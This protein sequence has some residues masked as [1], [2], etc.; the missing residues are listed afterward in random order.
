MSGTASCS[1]GPLREDS[2]TVFRLWAPAADRVEL[3][4]EGTGQ[5]DGRPMERDPAGWHRLRV[6]GALPGT[7]YRF[8]LP[9]GLLVPDPASRLQLLDAEGPSVVVDDRGYP[10]ANPD[11]TDMIARQLALLADID[12]GP[13]G[14]IRARF[15]FAGIAGSSAQRGAVDEQW[16]HRHLVDTA[17]RTLGLRTPRRSS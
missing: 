15:V 13:Q 3:V 11:W 12:P 10:W 9:D 2:A 5:A 4:L 1:F 14:M 6:E 17:R 16:L 8:R 7:A